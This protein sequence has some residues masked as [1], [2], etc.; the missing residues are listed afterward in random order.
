MQAYPD[1]GCGM[2]LGRDN[3]IEK[4]K[5][6]ENLVTDKY[7]RIYFKMDPLMIYKE[8]CEAQK[9]GL[10][11]IGFYH[12]HPDK[13]AIPSKTDE[14]YMIPGML[15]IIVSVSLNGVREIKAYYRNAADEKI[16]EAE[17]AKEEIQN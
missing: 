10:E 12:S 15:Y 13:R 8:E 17:I 2:L 16:T 9:E 6:A 11:V 1:E 5:P 14:E 7:G 4:I 3:R